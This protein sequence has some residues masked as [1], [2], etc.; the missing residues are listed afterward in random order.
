MAH[1]V[2]AFALI[3]AA[4]QVYNDDRISVPVPSGWS[5]NPVTANNAGVLVGD[6]TNQRPIGAAFI[7]GRY[8]LYLL[9]HYGQASGIRGGRFG[10]VAKYVA[11]WV[12]QTE[13]WPCISFLQKITTPV[14][15]RLSRVD[16]YFDTDKAGADALAQC[17]HPSQKAVLWY[18]SYFTH[19]CSPITSP[20]CS[21]FFLNFPLLAGGSPGLQSP[22][23]QMAFTLTF[24]PASPDELPRK[25]DPQ[26]QIFLTQGSRVVRRI[27]FK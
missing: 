1:I 21:G 26:L 9:T 24:R 4:Q 6:T 15:N 12:D 7:T 16:L 5:I 10:E 14:T 19:T 18:G 20:D 22:E 17:G 2:F 25:G 13:L 3:T 8:E 23:S 27:K 11:P